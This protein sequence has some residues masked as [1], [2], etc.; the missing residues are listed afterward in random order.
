MGTFGYFWKLLTFGKVEQQLI[1]GT[2]VTSLQSFIQYQL[3]LPPLEIHFCSTK[4]ICSGN[5]PKTCKKWVGARVFCLGYLKNAFAFEPL[6]CIVL[7]WMMNPRDLIKVA[8]RLSSLTGGCL[9]LCKYH[10]FPAAAHFSLLTPIVPPN[11]PF[12][13]PLSGRWLAPIAHYRL[14]G[15]S[16]CQPSLPPTPT[17]MEIWFILLALKANVRITTR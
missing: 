14:R 16:H 7:P 17:P 13:T 3:C 4:V 15:S 12:Y 11:P 8:W 2:D 5:Y 1:G 10:W 9:V 6:L